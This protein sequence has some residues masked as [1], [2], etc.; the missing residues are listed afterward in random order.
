LRENVIRSG[1]QPLAL[2]LIAGRVRELLSH[3]AGGNRWGQWLKAWSA[4][5]QTM[6]HR[7]WQTT[8]KPPA[9][10]QVYGQQT[11]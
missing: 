2:D 11:T 3:R 4:R 9:Q 10:D 1:N 7:I 5:A 8:K 6:F